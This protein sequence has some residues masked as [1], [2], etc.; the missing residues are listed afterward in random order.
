M[1]GYNS[2]ILKP[3]YRT[4][5]DPDKKIIWL[6]GSTLSHNTEMFHIYSLK[7]NFTILYIHYT[8][9]FTHFSERDDSRKVPQRAPEI[10][11]MKTGV[12]PGR[13]VVQ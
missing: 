6:N 11:E 1:K 5:N 4:K 8:G 3:L 2:N 10:Q 13:V 9:C 7:D 12:W